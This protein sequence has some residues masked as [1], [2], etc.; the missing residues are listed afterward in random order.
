M[1]KPISIWLF[2]AA[3]LSFGQESGQ[4]YETFRV[5]IHQLHV[6]VVDR[7]R[8]PVEGLTAEDFSVRLNGELQSIE[9]V[10]EISL[11]RDVLEA[12]LADFGAE[13]AANP[14]PEHGRRLF[15]FV[16]DL[17][18]QSRQGLVNA[19]RAAH[20]FLEN[21]LLETD[22]AAVITISQNGLIMAVNFTND[23][24]QLAFAFDTLGFS[25]RRMVYDRY[26]GY[27][28]PELIREYTQ[29]QFDRQD[30]LEDLRA[31]VGFAGDGL[32]NPTSAVEKALFRRNTG[33]AMN[34]MKVFKELGKSLEI[35]RG[36]K[37]VVFFS[38]GFNINY[39]VGSEGNGYLL[40]MMREAV[41]NLQGSGSVV[42]AVDTSR[43]DFLG[44]K[45]NLDSLN[46]IAADS[47]GRLFANANRGDKALARIESTTSHYYLVNIRTQLDLPKGE[48]A[49]VRVE[50]NRP[51]TRVFAPKGLLLE[52]DFQKSTP[53]E[54]KFLLSEFIAK[55]QIS[56]AMPISMQT[57][58]VPSQDD[59][60]R[61][62]VLMGLD[63]EYVDHQTLTGR[64]IPLEVFTIAIDKEDNRLVQERIS[65]FTIRPETG[66]AKKSVHTLS[67][68]KLAPGRYK[69]KTVVRNS[70]NGQIASLIRDVD[71]F[72]PDIQVTG[73][74][75][76]LAENAV[77]AH[78]QPSD[79]ASTSQPYRVGNLDFTPTASPRI[80][81]SR[82]SAFVFLLD[83]HAIRGREE[84]IEVKALLAGEDQSVRTIPPEAMTT[85]VILRKDPKNPALLLFTVD[86]SVLD[87]EPQ[88]EM[89][90]LTQVILQGEPPIRGALPLVFF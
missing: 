10:Q 27:T 41:E 49:R 47:G 69:I 6:N 62:D 65:G 70:A 51:G 35:L 71:L 61:L 74:L 83:A 88:Q 20:G 5:K 4:I 11:I 67:T 75:P 3:G 38:E 81:S 50:V 84:G 29:R 1:K 89:Q 66:A 79:F 12:G 56:L 21:D 54:R 30:D 14:I 57:I 42:F 37:N 85:R 26:S 68:L 52:P 31:L 48:I 45:P 18:Y 86:F 36:R 33:L 39:A 17:Q 63:A 44:N 53:L 82:R 64:A 76:T 9:S 40:R 28:P 60:M 72:S 24:E 59:L 43:P 25:G 15:L 32:T 23:R 55:D 7:K 73:P 78:A 8:I 13:P 2:L 90:L 80:S 58:Q 34:Y 87:M 46:M 22:L 77:L 19:R 16:F